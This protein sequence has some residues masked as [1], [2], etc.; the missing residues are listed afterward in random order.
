LNSWWGVY[1]LGIALDDNDLIQLGAVGYNL[2]VTAAAEYWLDLYNDNL[3]G[4]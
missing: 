2:E 4:I 3:P 1:L